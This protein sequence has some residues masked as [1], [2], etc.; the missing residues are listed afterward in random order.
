M[1]ELSELS[2]RSGQDGAEIVLDDSNI[3]GGTLR[4][5]GSKRFN[6]TTTVSVIFNA[7]T[8]TLIGL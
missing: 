3:R 4:R 1:A 5:S 2:R 6:R 7:I 8:Y